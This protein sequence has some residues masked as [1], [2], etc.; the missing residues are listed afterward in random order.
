VVRFGIRF[1]DGFDDGLNPAK[2]GIQG[3]D[4]MFKLRPREIDQQAPFPMTLLHF[5]IA[6]QSQEA[7]G[8]ILA[9]RKSELIK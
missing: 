8:G 5:K 1:N 7:L 9:W 6:F 4:Q 2:V 3:V